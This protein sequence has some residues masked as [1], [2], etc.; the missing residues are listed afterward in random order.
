MY[1]FLRDI[2]HLWLSRKDKM[3]T[4]SSYEIESSP[5]PVVHISTS[6]FIPDMQRSEAWVYPSGANFSLVKLI[7]LSCFWAHSGVVRVIENEKVDLFFFVLFYYSSLLTVEWA[8]RMNVVRQPSV[9]TMSHVK[10]E[11]CFPEVQ[12]M[13]RLLLCSCER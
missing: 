2:T 5:A 12:V 11:R 4:V 9:T 7:A 13:V 10:V 3:T 8:K 1:P 6:Y